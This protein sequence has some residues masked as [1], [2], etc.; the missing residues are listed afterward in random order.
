MA[1][2]AE[3]V[4]HNVISQE[5]IREMFVR[6]INPRTSALTSLAVRAGVLHLGWAVGELGCFR[7]PVGTTCP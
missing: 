7:V 3:V 1:L 2:F 4:R 6:N 5:L